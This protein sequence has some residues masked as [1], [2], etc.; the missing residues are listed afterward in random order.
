MLLFAKFIYVVCALCVGWE[1]PSAVGHWQGGEGIRKDVC[2]HNATWHTLPEVMP[3][4]ARRVD[5]ASPP[6][7][8]SRNFINIKS[9]YAF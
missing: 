3:M 1:D 7:A 2:G 6:C 5:V 8:M 4:H 9:R